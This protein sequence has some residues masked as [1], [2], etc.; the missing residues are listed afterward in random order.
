MSGNRE[1]E[2]APSEAYISDGESVSWL[3]DEAEA[4]RARY[5]T[6]DAVAGASNLEE[7][8]VALRQLYFDWYRHGGDRTHPGLGVLRAD[9]WDA[10]E[11]LREAR[12]EQ[13]RSKSVIAEDAN[14]DAAVSAAEHFEEAT[15]RSALRALEWREDWRKK[16]EDLDL[17]HYSRHYTGNVPGEGNDDGSKR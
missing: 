9:M 12:A 10:Y 17:D 13:R 4:L 2:G 14:I 16:G 1:T 11:L 5:A 15:R 7:L 3:S 6:D 8:A